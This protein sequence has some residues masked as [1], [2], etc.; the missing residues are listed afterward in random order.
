[1]AEAKAA[2]ASKKGAAKQG[3]KSAKGKKAAGNGATRPPRTGVGEF[4]KDQLRLKNPP[5]NEEIAD[6][7]R[8]KFAGSRTTPASVSWYRNKV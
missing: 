8:A 3:K 1:M 6:K 5:S 4:I 2:E 7:C